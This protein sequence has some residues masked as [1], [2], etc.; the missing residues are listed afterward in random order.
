AAVYPQW[1]V[2][3]VRL[4][5]EQVL[6]VVA[7]CRQGRSRSKV[8]L[9]ARPFG[10][11]VDDATNELLDRTLTLGRS[12]VAAE[13]FRDHDIGRFLRP[14]LRDL[15]ATLLEHNMTL[16]VADDGVAQIPLDLV[17]WVIP[18]LSKETGKLQT[19]GSLSCPGRRLCWG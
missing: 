9:A 16:L 2:E 4:R 15:D 8:L 18:R 11:R 1:A 3:R 19:G 14:R 12:D 13:V 6:Q 10:D 7:E 5:N 17:E